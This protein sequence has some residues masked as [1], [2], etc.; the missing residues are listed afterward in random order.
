MSLY[1]LEH[2]V[3]RGFGDYRIHFAINCASK[4]CPPLEATPFRGRDLD[5]R[6]DAAAER[7]VAVNVILYK[8]VLLT[9]S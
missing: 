9:L 7:F 5:A 2:D 6:L 8:F 4:S 1:A 3:I